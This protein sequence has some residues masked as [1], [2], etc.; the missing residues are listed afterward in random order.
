MVNSVGDCLL[1]TSAMR[2]CAVFFMG[3]SFSDL[4]DLL[5]PFLDNFRITEDTGIISQ[6]L[7][8]GGRST[9]ATR[10]GIAPCL[11]RSRQL[12]GCAVG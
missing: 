11:T 6:N 5:I 4:E 3:N 8:A 2:C 10:K 1:G 12:A 9:L 7:I